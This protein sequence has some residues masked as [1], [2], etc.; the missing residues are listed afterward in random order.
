M[1]HQGKS[2]H[3]HLLQ[4]ELY[5]TE[6]QHISFTHLSV[7]PISPDNN[8]LKKKKEKKSSEN[9][10]S[11]ILWGVIQSV[12]CHLA[13][14]FALQS[15][16]HTSQHNSSLSHYRA[17]HTEFICWI[18]TRSSYLIRGVS[19]GSKA[20]KKNSIREQ[21]FQV[22]ADGRNQNHANKTVHRVCGMPN[23]S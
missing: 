22:R 6:T 9:I 13:D 12:V 11:T 10:T 8:D 4:K 14:L 16:T 3:I 2:A 15:E 19:D 17:M 23:V 1:A 20:R 5:Y 21:L 18:S 7:L